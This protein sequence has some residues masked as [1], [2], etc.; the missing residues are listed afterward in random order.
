MSA[1]VSRVVASSLLMLASACALAAD[2]DEPDMAFLEYL[3]MWEES[4][5]EWLAFENDRDE[6]AADSDRRIES[7]P[8]SEESQEYEDDS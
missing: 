3:G 7:A 6:V 1:S 4:D 8:D 2:E 5:E